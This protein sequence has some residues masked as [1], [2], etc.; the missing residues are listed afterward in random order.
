LPRSTSSR[1][2]FARG[3]SSAFCRSRSISCFVHFLFIVILFLEE[4]ANKGY[5][6]AKVSE[7]A[8]DLENF[9]AVDDR[10]VLHDQIVRDVSGERKTAETV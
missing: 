9:L 6:D 8:H 10:L 1:S 5:V 7:R 2:R 4:P 3:S